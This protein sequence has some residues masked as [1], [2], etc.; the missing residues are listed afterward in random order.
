[1]SESE[2]S[3]PSGRDHGTVVQ[4][5]GQVTLG[6]EDF[7]S[8]FLALMSGEPKIRTHLIIPRTH[9]P[10]VFKSKEEKAVEAAFE[11]CA[12]KTVMSCV[13]DS[14]QFNIRFKDLL[15]KKII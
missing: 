2:Y 7:K 1:M 3:H 10:V 14:H 13:L 9:G 15:C 12:F 11:S 8:V 5:N 6:T 4:P